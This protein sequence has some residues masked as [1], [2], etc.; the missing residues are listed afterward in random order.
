MFAALPDVRVTAVMDIDLAR[1]EWVAAAVGARVYATLDALLA[2]A[3]PDIVAVATPPDTHAAIVRAALLAGKH[4]FCEPPAALTLGETHALFDLAWQSGRLFVLDHPLRHNPFWESVVRLRQDGLLGDLLHIDIAN[5]AAGTDLPPSHWFWDAKQSGG[6][7]VEHGV[8]FFDA[9]AWLAGDEGTVQAAQSFARAD[10]I[11]DGVEA[12]T[13]FGA[14]S[15][16]FY[17]SF[18]HDAL[19]AQTTMYLT[20]ARGYA[21]L[22]DWTPTTIEIW[23]ATTPGQIIPY[24]V[25]VTE[26]LDEASSGRLRHW[27][28]H[29][30]EGKDAIRQAA[31]QAGMS[32]LVRAVCAL[33]EGR[34]AEAIFTAWRGSAEIEIASLRMALEA[35]ERTL[36]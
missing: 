33:R 34:D 25:G 22:R 1:A 13:T 30:P 17:H 20:F 10:G 2:D 11:V 31:L 28:S 19:T 29:A 12:M 8:H 35:G 3:E 7:W 5:H 32:D 36:S 6:I 27:M 23:A 14:V 9:C 21:M 15:A 18:M 16:H 26:A 24:L 4:V